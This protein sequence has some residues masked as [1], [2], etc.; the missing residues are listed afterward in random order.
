M[1]NEPEFAAGMILQ[2]KGNGSHFRVEVL[3][4][5]GRISLKRIAGGPVG[6][7][8]RATREQVRMAYEPVE[9]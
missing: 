9:K 8:I 1:K 6:T 2:G 5:R 4:A 3:S 7:I